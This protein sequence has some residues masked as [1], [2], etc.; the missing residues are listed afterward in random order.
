MKTAIS[1]LLEEQ[2]DV[3][4]QLSES[5]DFERA[6]D[7]LEELIRNGHETGEI[8][9]LLADTL[10]VLNGNSRASEYYRRVI[11]LTSTG[12]TTESIKLNLVAKMELVYNLLE[13]IQVD[14]RTLA[15]TEQDD[16]FNSRLEYLAAQVPFKNLLAESSSLQSV[17]QRSSGCGACNHGNGRWSG[18]R[19]LSC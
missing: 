3:A 15:E 18:F 6:I 5:K 1:T 4:Y 19:C 2:L 12:E 14:Y 7:K 10:S 8:C 13:E 9:L 16:E 17:L 11:E